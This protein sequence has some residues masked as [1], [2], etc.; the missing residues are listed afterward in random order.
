M[1]RSLA[2]LPNSGY[3]KIGAYFCGAAAFYILFS[4]PMSYVKHSRVDQS[5]ND[6][7]TC[8]QRGREGS[9][10]GTDAALAPT[11]S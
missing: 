10:E 3:W 4:L 9:R 5:S 11:L 2:A 8:E 6:D 1:Y 7:L